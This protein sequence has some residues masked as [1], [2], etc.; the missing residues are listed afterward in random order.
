MNIQK[1]KIGDIKPNKEN[2]RTI[3]IDKRKKLVQSIKDF[4]QMLEIRPIVVDDTMTILGGNMRYSACKEAGLDE[5][6][7]IKASDLTE[8]QKKEFVIKDNVGFGDW[9][10]DVLANGWDLDELEKWGLDVGY[11]SNTPADDFYS[12]K[13]E[14]PKY[15]PSSV[16]PDVSRLV[17]DKKVNELLDKIDKSTLSK[18]DKAFLTTA[19]MRHLVFDYGKI[20][21]YYAH[22]NQEL[23]ELMEESALVIIDFD[24]AIEMGY[25]KLSESIAEQYGEE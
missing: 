9:D 10:W 23:Q 13:I 25:V 22:A 24:K 1:V 17:D 3:S 11:L 19:A 16:K 6:W 5:I 18:E 2:P 15:E 21:D 4:P 12:K 7:I 14:A 20:A 8:E